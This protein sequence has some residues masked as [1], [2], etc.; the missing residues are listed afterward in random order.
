MI[1]LRPSRRTAR[2]T[3][4]GSVLFACGCGAARNPDTT[5]S[6]VLW[7][8]SSAEYE[9]AATGIYGAATRV[10]ELGWADSSWTA[11]TEQEG[12]YRRL[13]AAVIVDVDETVLDNTPYQ[14]RLIEDG[15][16]YGPVSWG[17]W[18][19]EAQAPAVPGALEFTR[20]A[21]R[22]GVT[23]FYV[24]NRDSAL[25]DAT[26]ANLE[27]LGFPFAE[28]TDVILTRGERSQWGSDKSTRRAHVAQSF[29]IVLLVG[30]DL[31]DFVAADRASVT[32]RSALVQR[33]R[34][35]WGT[36]WIVLP[37]PMYGSWE[38]SLIGNVDLSE[39]D[40]LQLKRRRLEAA[41]Q[42]PE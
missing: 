20:A 42:P 23:V 4:L 19:A 18:V 35:Y 21:A 27:R 26:R 25:E 10:L 8:Q 37:N 1:V 2:T 34:A 11:A 30:D 9:A 14:A 36:R 13:P 16:L 28:G 7:V 32:E 12:D 39:D 40:V 3:A 6:A 41:R 29:R 38:R 24:T 33:Y 22:T 5:L 15:A 17:A 31:N